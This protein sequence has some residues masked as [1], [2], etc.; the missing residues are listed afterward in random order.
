MSQDTHQS[1]LHALDTSIP[2][3]GGYT[4]RARMIVENQKR[5]G[6]DPAVIT[7]LRQPRPV[8]ETGEN[9][10]FPQEEYGGI[11]YFRS[12]DWRFARAVRGWG[13]PVLREVSEMLPFG[14]TLR[15]IAQSLASTIIHAHSPILVGY[16]ALRAA[17]R[18]GIPFVYEIRAFWEDAAVDQKKSAAGSLRYRLT[19]F[20]ETRLITKSDAVVVICEGLQNDLIERGVKAEKIFIV[21]NGVDTETFTPIPEDAELRSK[22][23]FSGKTV[24]GYIGTFY[25][26]EGL[27]FLIEAMEILR[28]RD[29]IVCLIVGY[30][31]AD[32]EIRQLVEELGLAHRVHFA[33]KVPNYKVQSYYSIVDILVYPRISRR[34]TELV[35]PLKPLEAMAMGKTVLASNVGGLRELIT[36]GQ[37]GILFEPENASDLA[38]KIC[39]LIDRGDLCRELGCRARESMLAKRS[40]ADLVGHYRDVY[41]YAQAAHAQKHYHKRP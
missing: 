6:W 20:L 18:L 29:D 19:R 37:D 15:R 22:L 7:F 17:R 27:R 2:A 26:F 39:H 36:D 28:E 4:T 21:P 32:N 24:V 1:I 3:I 12:E 34:I 14:T 33:G 8:I 25:N 40:W 41:D 30:G 31:E 23:G 10:S 35:T 13:V 38:E 11:R 5:A 9:G 16:P